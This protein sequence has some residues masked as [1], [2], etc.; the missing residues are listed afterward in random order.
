MIW[1]GAARLRN[2]LQGFARYAVLLNTEVFSKG[3]FLFLRPLG[4]LKR[5]TKPMSKDADEL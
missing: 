1:R 2:D 5:A 3:I 4:D